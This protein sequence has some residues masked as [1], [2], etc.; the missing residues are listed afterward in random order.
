MFSRTKRVH[1]SIG[2]QCSGSV[3][4]FKECNRRECDGNYSIYFNK[5]ISIFYVIVVKSINNFSNL[6]DGCKWNDWQEGKCSKSCGGGKMTRTR[7]QAMFPALGGKKCIGEPS[8]TVSC[9]IQECPG[10]YLVYSTACQIVISNA[11][12]RKV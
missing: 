9:N 6:L 8:I 12:C 11:N 2:G 3:S 10:N 4:T 5:T 7:T 1:E